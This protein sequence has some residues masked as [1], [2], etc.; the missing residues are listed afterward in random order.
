M[1]QTPIEWMEEFLNNGKQK[2]EGIISLA[3]AKAKEMER[4]QLS[5]MYFGGSLKMW[6]T[7][8]SYKEYY[9]EIYKNKI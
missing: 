7:E 2:S 9:N 3:I 1:K 4:E 5:D 8:R 6:P